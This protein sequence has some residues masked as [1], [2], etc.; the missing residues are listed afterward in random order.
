MVYW[1]TGRKNAGKTTIG[2]QIVRQTN[3]ILLDG[4]D[5]REY[6]PT[7]YS[8]EDRK[9]NIMRIAKTAALIEKQGHIVV[10]ACVSPKREWRKEAQRLFKEYIEIFIPGGELWDGTEYE[11]PID[12]YKNN[13]EKK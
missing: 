5:F 12:V 7:G 13:N 2:N 9:D 1:L 6:F 10:I 8:D 4:D 3:G 11:E